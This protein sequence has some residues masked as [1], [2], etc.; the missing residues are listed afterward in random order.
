MSD[1]VEE[2]KAEIGVDF[3]LEIDENNNVSA[4]T[5]DLTF[6]QTTKLTQLVTALGE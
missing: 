2:I 4:D 1:I 6:D 5:S 3:H